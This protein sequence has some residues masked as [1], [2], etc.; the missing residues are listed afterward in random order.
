MNMNMNSGRKPFNYGKP[1]SGVFIRKTE[2]GISCSY[3]GRNN[4]NLEELLSSG[5]L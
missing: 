1:Y 4:N 2:G 3:L 5:C